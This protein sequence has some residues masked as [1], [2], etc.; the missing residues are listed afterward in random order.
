MPVGKYIDNG[1]GSQPLLVQLA[2]LNTT[3]MNQNPDVPAPPAPAG[4]GDPGVS[5][6]HFDFDI[7]YPARTAARASTTSTSTTTPMT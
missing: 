3:L 2:T 7:Y 1:I 5:N 4:T 6:G